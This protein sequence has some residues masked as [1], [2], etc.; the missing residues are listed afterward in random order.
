MKKVGVETKGTLSMSQKESLPTS[1]RLLA[2]AEPSLP[3]FGQDE[4]PLLAN[5][6]HTF[7][8]VFKINLMA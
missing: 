3:V 1:Q 4:S 7:F 8:P 6:P 5:V 2:R